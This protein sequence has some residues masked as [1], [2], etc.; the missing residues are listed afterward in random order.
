MC[1][2][3]PSK[4]QLRVWLRPPWVLWAR[5]A[6]SQPAVYTRMYVPVA[7]HVWGVCKGT[8]VHVLTRGRTHTRVLHMC[9]LRE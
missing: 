7:V 5:A 8:H 4:E 6:P 9:A 1:G 2:T 3:S